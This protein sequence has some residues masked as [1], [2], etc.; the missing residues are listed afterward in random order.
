L[1]IWGR[2]NVDHATSM[3]SS[4]KQIVAGLNQQTPRK[5]SSDRES[6][7]F[8]VESRHRKHLDIISKVL[9]D[10][11]INQIYGVEEPHIYIGR[12][13][14]ETQYR[15]DEAQPAESFRLA[16]TPLIGEA[17]LQEAV[18]QGLIRRAIPDDWDRWVRM[19]RLPAQ[20]TFPVQSNR[21]M[22][23]DL[24][25]ILKPFRL[26]AGL[27]GAQ[28]ANFILRARRRVS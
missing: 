20:D 3:N 23:R 9:F 26:P 16:G 14:A 10:Q 4:D 18:E 2:S 27:Y 8:S 28:S 7:A 22:P 19:T 24:Y 25:V 13:I 11:P 6:C 15:Q 21:D 12:P 17:G 5:M 1:D